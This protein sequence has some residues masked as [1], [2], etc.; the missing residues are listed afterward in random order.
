MITITVQYPNN[1]QKVEQHR[2]FEIEAIAGAESETCDITKLYLRYKKR[3]D[4]TPPI[5]NPTQLAAAEA[6]A[7]KQLWQKCHRFLRW[8]RATCWTSAQLDIVLKALSITGTNNSTYEL[9]SAEAFIR[10]AKT[11]QLAVL[12][13]TAPEKVAALWGNISTRQYINFNSDN[14]DLLPS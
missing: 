2:T 7:Q 12:L 3:D 4:V 5:P 10:V 11:H 8:K 6:D 14:Q 9:L 1:V 13:G